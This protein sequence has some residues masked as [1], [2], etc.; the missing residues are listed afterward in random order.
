MIV[1]GG[2]IAV[3]LA[4]LAHH[5]GWNDGLAFVLSATAVTPL[6]GVYLV[7]A[8]GFWWG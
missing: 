7:I 1:G 8:A 3:L 2:A 5:G 6:I 4:G